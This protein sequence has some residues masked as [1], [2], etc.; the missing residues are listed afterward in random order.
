MEISASSDGCAALSS[1]R[2]ATTARSR[3][4]CSG[5]DGWG[6]CRRHIEFQSATVRTRP[7][8]LSS[9]PNDVFSLAAVLAPAWVLVSGDG[10]EEDTRAADG[11]GSRGA[12]D[13]AVAARPGAGVHVEAGEGGGAATAASADSAS[14]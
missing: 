11:E 6:V 14:A 12:E 9:R 13:D 3:A 2:T 5:H 4:G 1:S 7:G 10:V 8:R